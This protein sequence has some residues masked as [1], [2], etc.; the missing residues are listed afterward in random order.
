[1]FETVLVIDDDPIFCEITQS[2]LKE[3]GVREVF[4]ARNGHDGLGILQQ[5]SGRIDFIILDLNMPEIDGI[6]FLNRLSQMSF[7]GAIAIVSSEVPV[8]IDM[9]ASLGKQYNLN[10]VDAHKKPLA[11]SDI[12]RWFARRDG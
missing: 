6:E 12:D 2:Y 7:S 11:K 1:M 3:S 8:V 4:V 5:N 9:A 10:I